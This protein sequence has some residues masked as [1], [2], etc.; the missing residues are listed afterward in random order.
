M[1]FLLSTSTCVSG[2]R[3]YL[4]EILPYPYKMSKK[5]DEYNKYLS[6]TI[7]TITSNDNLFVDALISKY[8]NK[9][10]LAVIDF[11]NSHVLT[12]SD[13]ELYIR[14]EELIRDSNNKNNDINN[15]RL[16]LKLQ[17]KN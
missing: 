1:L 16:L 17:R 15:I 7:N 8:I 4:N 13:K 2:Y 5:L 11:F 6:S 9:N 3:F 14:Y 10:E 12:P